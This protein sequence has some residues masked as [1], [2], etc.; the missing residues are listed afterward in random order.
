MIRKTQKK[1]KTKKSVFIEKDFKSGDGMLTSVWGPSLWHSL[2]TISFNYP[3]SPSYKDKIEYRKFILQL[4]HVLPCKYCRINFKENLKCLPLTMKQMESRYT[5][6]KYMYDL[7]ELINKML[8]KKSNLSYCEVRERY[9]H[10]RSRCTDDKDL[11]VNKIKKAKTDSD[12]FPRDLK[13]LNTRPEIENLIGIYC[14]LTKTKPENLFSDFNN[15][16][17]SYFK[18][19]LAEVVNDKI[20]PI[21]REIQK[22]NN[23]VEYIDKVLEQG[24]EK[25]YELSS[26]KIK[27]LKNKFGF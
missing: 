2:H 19:K 23:D 9:E 21:S 5:F 12:P 13:S 26:K 1:K 6:S 18:K 20:F 4:K 27:Q 8:K 3:I 11:I 25:A 24:S 17:F 10:F 7:H 22:L 14:S 16:N 15:K